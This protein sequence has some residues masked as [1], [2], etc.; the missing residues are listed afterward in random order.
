[1]DEVLVSE[2]VHIPTG[3]VTFEGLFEKEETCH[4]FTI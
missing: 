4:R 2:P 3:V 1:M